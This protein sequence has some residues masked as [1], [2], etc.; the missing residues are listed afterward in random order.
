[1]VRLS[2]AE[3]PL[4]VLSLTVSISTKMLRLN[5]F[6]PMQDDFNKYFLVL[7]VC[8]ALCWDICGME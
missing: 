4:K 5:F 8:K 1:M 3:E 6:K 7:I 2:F